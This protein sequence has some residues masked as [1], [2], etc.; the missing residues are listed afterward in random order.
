M[1]KTNLKRRG[2]VWYARVVIPRAQRNRLGGKTDLQ[3]SLK[4]TSLVEA[5]RLRHRVVHEL[6]EEISRS[7]L[8]AETPPG[9]VEYVMD[10]AR[11]SRAAVLDGSM[12]EENAELALDA[13]VE[14]FLEG[15]AQER[16]V[17]DD[18]GDP[19]LTDAEA[20]ALRLAHKVFSGEQTALL[21]DQIRS[22]LAEEK[23]R[24]TAGA[25]EDKRR[26][27][28]AFARWAGNIEVSTITRTL[29]G[30]YVQE[31]IQ[32]SNLEPKSRK[33][34]LSWLNAF[35]DYLETY[36]YVEV[37]PFV[38]LGKRMKESTRGGVKPKLRAWTPAEYRGLVERLPA[39]S[40]LLPMAL[41]AGYSAMRIDE[42]ANMRLEHVTGDAF[43]IVEGK[44]GNS[45]RVVPMHP[46]LA[47]AVERLRQTSDDGYLISGLLPGGR[48][49][50]RSH[51]PSKYFGRFIRA[52]G[53]TD[54]LL[55]FH[56]LRRSW[57][58][59]AETAK[60]PQ[61]TC[62]LIDGHARQN[63]S[64]GLYSDGPDWPVLVEA[65]GK[66]SYGDACDA[67]ATQR[68]ANCEVTERMKRRVFRK[69]RGTK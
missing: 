48:D 13:T 69:S 19:N 47:P 44:T 16:G 55:N 1:D 57:T 25:L 43:R 33:K 54:S 26:R 53:F 66:V 40:P 11:A 59:R 7:V 15:A 23:Q 68:A 58:Q 36:R 45:V 50:K 4:T 34:W 63:L 62:N 24:I 3:R 12:D 32:T 65:M 30:R 22:H 41:I 37:N 60:V 49:N 20:R 27:L 67:L 5:R 52:N 14:R 29:A 2:Q 61:S 8:A 39:G 10:A 64:Y 51:F 28:E 38:N 21:K 35:G 9:T 17:D 18:D 46:A 42:I 31:V 6:Q 56:G